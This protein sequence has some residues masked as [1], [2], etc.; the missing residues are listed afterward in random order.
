MKWGLLALVLI[1]C[2]KPQKA[3]EETQW[4]DAANDAPVDSIAVEKGEWRGDGV[5]VWVAPGWSGT[6]TEGPPE[7]LELVDGE[8]ATV[9]RVELGADGLD[10]PRG[11]EALFEDSGTYRS[12]PLD[13]LQTASCVDEDGTLLQVWV[14]RADFVSVRV[15][16]RYPIGRAVSGRQRAET[17][18][19]TLSAAGGA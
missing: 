9:L 1:G 19:S 15:E 6:H 18:L 2:P 17:I 16:A 3:P 5:T 10:L 7:V 13:E 8:T 14:G 11:C 4:L 12:V